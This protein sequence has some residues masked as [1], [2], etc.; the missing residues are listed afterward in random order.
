MVHKTCDG[1]REFCAVSGALRTIA[2]LRYLS[3]LAVV[4]VLWLGINLTVTATD[5][6]PNSS[7]CTAIQTAANRL[8]CA[9]G[10]AQ[11]CCFFSSSTMLSGRVFVNGDRA[12]ES[13]C[14]CWQAVC[15]LIGRAVIWLLWVAGFVVATRLCSEVRFCLT[16]HWCPARPWHGRQP[17][18]ICGRLGKTQK[19]LRNGLRDTY[20]TWRIHV[21]ELVSRFFEQALLGLR[22]DFTVFLERWAGTDDPQYWLSLGNKLSPGFSSSA[23]LVAVWWL[24][25]LC[26]LG[27]AYC[28]L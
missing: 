24:R 19:H 23:P 20:L 4:G 25:T 16:L 5:S 10:S 1:S 15:W 6:Y 11:S 17:A 26:W 28:L 21:C 18:S 2:Q 22:R 14:I 12:R 3:S 13:V 9:R 27:H 8:S 7:V